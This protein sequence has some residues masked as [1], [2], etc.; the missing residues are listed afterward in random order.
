MHACTS[1]SCPNALRMWKAPTPCAVNWKLS[2]PSTHSTGANCRSCSLRINQSVSAT[3]FLAPLLSLDP[4][5]SS[6]T[7]I[8]AIGNPSVAATP[9]VSLVSVAPGTAELDV[10]LSDRCSSARRPCVAAAAVTD[11]HGHHLLAVVA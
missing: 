9:A 10:P 4:S 2:I 5:R 7:I 11:Q 6:F 8:T 1:T 3:E